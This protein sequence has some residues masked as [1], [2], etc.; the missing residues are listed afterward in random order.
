MKEEIERGKG[1]ETRAAA[2]LVLRGILAGLIVPFAETLQTVCEA[3]R[4]FLYVILAAYL[5]FLLKGLYYAVRILGITKQ[6]RITPDTV[7]DFQDATLQDVLRD[8]IAATVWAYE[9]AK[10]PN[11][12][13]L[14]WLSRSQRN[15]VIAIFLYVLFGVSVL[16]FREGLVTPS[17]PAMYSLAAVAAVAWVF[18]DR[19]AEAERFGVWRRS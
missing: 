11:T 14:Y 3:G 1:A 7:C 10:K 16:I 8:D 15:A 5:L 17:P 19:P 2:I 13:K 6:V 9:Q 4:W 18:L 12:K